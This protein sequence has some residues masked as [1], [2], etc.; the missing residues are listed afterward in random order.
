[1]YIRCSLQGLWTD[2]RGLPTVPCKMTWHTDFLADLAVNFTQ[3]S[4]RAKNFTGMF[5]TPSHL[6]E[7]T[8]RVAWAAF[9][10]VPRFPWPR[11]VGTSRK[12]AGSSGY[13]EGPLMEFMHSLYFT[14]P[15]PLSMLFR[16]N[17]TFVPTQHWKWREGYSKYFSMEDHSSARRPEF[18]ET[19]KIQ[20][21]SAKKPSKCNRVYIE[22]I[23]SA[24][25]LTQ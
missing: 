1:M 12:A 17:C 5:C 23:T 16:Y 14:T 18:I 10:F 7:S 6:E 4:L 19:I 2:A 25:E 8:P 15:T 13:P 9:R 24:P 20:Q 3:A 22:T 11:T 21:T